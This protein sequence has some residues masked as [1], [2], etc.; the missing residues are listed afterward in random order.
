MSTVE[1]YHP[2]VDGLPRFKQGT[3][4]TEAVLVQRHAFPILKLLHP[5]TLVFGDILD[6]RKPYKLYSIGMVMSFLW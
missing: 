6:F 4:A 2:S 3:K 5:N 1:G